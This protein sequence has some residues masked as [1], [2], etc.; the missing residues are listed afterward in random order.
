MSSIDNSANKSFPRES[1]AALTCG[2]PPPLI[3][4]KQKSVTCR[5]AV[6]RFALIILWFPGQ[7]KAKYSRPF[8]AFFLLSYYSLSSESDATIALLLASA[9]RSTE[10]YNNNKQE[11]PK[12]Q[13]FISAIRKQLRF[14]QPAAV[15]NPD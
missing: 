7:L 9:T 4:A 8:L 1:S 11:L 10:G 3:W 14:E 6:C 15:S 13:I 5:F 12:Y 2:E